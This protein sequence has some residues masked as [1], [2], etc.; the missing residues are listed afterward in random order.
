MQNHIESHGREYA[1]ADEEVVM[2]RAG[3]WSSTLLTC[4]SRCP[5]SR[6]Q[7]SSRFACLMRKQARGET[8][9]ALKPFDFS[10]AAASGVHL[11]HRAAAAFRSLD[12]C[13][14]K[15]PEHERE[16]QLPSTMEQDLAL[17][18]KDTSRRSARLACPGAGRGGEVRHRDRREVKMAGGRRGPAHAGQEMGERQ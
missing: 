18:E 9:H 6:R 13:L 11:A 12:R 8:Q 1:D 16:W 3:S 17:Q 10:S 2:P 4:T 15:P 14:S 7:P 5:A